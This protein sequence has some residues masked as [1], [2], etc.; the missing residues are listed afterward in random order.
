MDHNDWRPSVFEFP[1][2]DN[3]ISSNPPLVVGAP[4]RSSS[5]GEILAWHSNNGSLDDTIR[6]HC[7]MER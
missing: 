5:P 3:G 7:G 6:E 2:A 4:T 1:E